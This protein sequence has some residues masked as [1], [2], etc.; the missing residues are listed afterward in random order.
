MNRSWTTILLIA[1]LAVL[2]ALLGVLQYRWQTQITENESER[3]HKR[4][5]AEAE[6]IGIAKPPTQR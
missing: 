3:M 5:Q 2:L 4:T 6:S 1:G